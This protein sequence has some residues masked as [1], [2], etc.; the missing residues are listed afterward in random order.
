M[1][2]DQKRDRMFK[3]IGGMDEWIDG[4]H[5]AMPKADKF[6]RR[7]FDTLDPKTAFCLMVLIGASLHGLFSAKATAE[8]AIDKDFFF[9]FASVVT[10]LMHYEDDDGDEVRH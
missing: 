6:Y 10:E 2:E 8:E 1:T 5:S 9:K 4:V 7:H 3:E